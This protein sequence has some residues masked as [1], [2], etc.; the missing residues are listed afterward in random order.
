MGVPICGYVAT[1][2]RVHRKVWEESN[3]L[4]DVF[5]TPLTWTKITGGIRS[6]PEF[7][8]DRDAVNDPQSDIDVLAQWGNGSYFQDRAK[9]WTFRGSV[10]V[11]PWT[12]EDSIIGR[13]LRANRKQ[14][15][16]CY[17]RPSRRVAARHHFP[18]G[19]LR[20]CGTDERGRRACCSDSCPGI[21]SGLSIDK[22][23]MGNVAA[24]PL[25]LVHAGAAQRIMRQQRV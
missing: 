25:V 17:R 21:S 14:G 18:F 7:N 10:E 13:R 8:Y 4:C 15:F 23:Q 2:T 5:G 12:A 22:L 20:N 6:W 24:T 9:S 11:P 1:S 16:P 19:A 3:T